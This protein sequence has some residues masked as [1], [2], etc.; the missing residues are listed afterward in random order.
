MTLSELVNL[1]DYQ[2]P[3]LADRNNNSTYRIFMIEEDN[4][5]KVSNTETNKS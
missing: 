3:I 1:L 2:F 4:A 5:Y